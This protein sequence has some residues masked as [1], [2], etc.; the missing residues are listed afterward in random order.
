LHRTIRNHISAW[1]CWCCE[2]GLTSDEELDMC[3]IQMRD[4]PECVEACTHRSRISGDR[5]YWC[6]VSIHI[7]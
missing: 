3:I 6:C 1:C 5:C 2:H 4:L 7:G